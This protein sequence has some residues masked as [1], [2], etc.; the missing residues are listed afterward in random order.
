MIFGR[1]TVPG[2][3]SLSEQ[4]D[5]NSPHDRVLRT[6]VSSVDHENGVAVVN[7][8]GLPSGG[9]Y[10]TVPP[11]WM[12]FPPDTASVGP[13]WGRYM[14]QPTDLIK[15]AFGHDNTP[16]GIGYDISAHREGVAD[17]FSGWP[18]LNR[19]YQ[20]AASNPS[21]QS[22]R[23]KFA[24]FIPLKPGE[25]D[26]MS[27][28]GAYIYG[29][30]RGRL[31]MAGGSVSVSLIKNELRMSTNAQFW[32]HTADECNLRFGQVRRVKDQSTGAE[33]AISDTAAREFKVEINR[34]SRKLVETSIGNVSSTSGLALKSTFDNS[35]L[36]RL[37]VFNAQSVA[38][39]EQNID[40]IGNIEIL[41]PNSS[42]G[43]FLDFSAGKWL[44]KNTEME[45]NASTKFSVVSPS[46]N[47]GS[48]DP[49]EQLVLGSTFIPSNV[50]WA[51][52]TNAAIAQLTVS[53]TS[54]VAVSTALSALLTAAA[55]PMAIPIVGPTIA[56]IIIAA[57]AAT[58]TGTA[59]A[60]SAS[61]API[62]PTAQAA[63]TAYV[64]AAGA[65]YLS[66][67]SRTK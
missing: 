13:A 21:T 3:A 53:G 63:C 33:V 30:N 20:E 64:T 67:I 36:S 38:V 44:S 66:V 41:A 39:L 52:S 56:A 26:F 58:I 11:L 16:F 17:D 60:V 48:T 43:I 6:Q 9:R 50:A 61:Y 27:S 59:A 46:V 37:A 35:I 8:D 57:G 1:R 4:L 23:K 45:L 47:L 18:E 7:Y 14:P 28:G 54:H 62:V 15:V 55:V 40:E 22:D 29:N 5:P 51:N 2:E 42:G 25:Y 32:L 65:R 49:T 31:Y 10:I 12:S 34:G 24:Q 19:L